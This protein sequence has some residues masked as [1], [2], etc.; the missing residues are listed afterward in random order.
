MP[1][2]NIGAP[3]F[4]GLRKRERLPEDYQR[5]RLWEVGAPL[6]IPILVFIWLVVDFSIGGHNPAKYPSDAIIAITGAG[7]FLIFG[8]LLILNVYGTIDLEAT[9][10]DFLG[11][12]EDTGKNRSLIVAGILLFFYALIRVKVHTT[13]FDKEIQFG[14]AI[15]STGVLVIVLLWIDNII[16]NL[17]LAKIRIAIRGSQLSAQYNVV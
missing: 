16:W 9:R 10:Y 6:G 14:I 7:D 15:L 13:P 8:A 4:R 2:Q 17:H 11:E 3:I 12:G 5:W 1:F